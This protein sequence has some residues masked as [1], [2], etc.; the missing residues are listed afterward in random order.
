VSYVYL[1]LWNLHSRT[2]LRGASQP[3][4]RLKSYVRLRT[5]RNNLPM[6]LAKCHNTVISEKR[7]ELP[8]TTPRTISE[9]GASTRL[10]RSTRSLGIRNNPLQEDDLALQ[11]EWNPLGAWTS[12]LERLIGES[13]IPREFARRA[14]GDSHLRPRC[15]NISLASSEF[16]GNQNLP[17][18][19][20]RFSR[21]APGGQLRRNAIF[22][23]RR[24]CWT[25]G[26]LGKRFYVSDSSR[27]CC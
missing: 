24:P 2:A 20:F 23:S 3:E 12:R 11:V 16:Q 10:A 21:N 27:R 22:R 19:A 9:S 6:S 13:R 25:S 18:T 26:R 1:K 5:F 7:E 4:D 15:W 14:L 8:S 17:R